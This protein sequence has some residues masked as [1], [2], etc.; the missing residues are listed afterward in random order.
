VSVSSLKGLLLILNYVIDLIRVPL[1]RLYVLR[2][3]ES[4]KTRKKKKKK[5]KTKKKKVKKIKR[6]FL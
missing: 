5:K 2:V 1:R 3:R 4:L 6:L